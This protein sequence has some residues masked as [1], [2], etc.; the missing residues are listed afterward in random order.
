MYLACL[1]LDH[2]EDGNEHEKKEYARILGLKKKDINTK[3]G[4][5]RNLRES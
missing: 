4:L 2:L 5:Y 3:Q 1:I